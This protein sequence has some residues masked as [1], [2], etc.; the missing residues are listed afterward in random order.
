MN[1]SDELHYLIQEPGIVLLKLLNNHV[2]LVC[3]ESGQSYHPGCPHG[4]YFPGYCV[5]Q[6]GQPAVD[7]GLDPTVQQIREYHLNS[8]VVQVGSFAI[9]VD[10]L[11]GETGVPV[12]QP[13]PSLGAHSFQYSGLA[14]RGVR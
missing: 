10:N 11:G 4:F 14:D 1:L 3:M 9:V 8:C 7:E 13:A 2:R 12:C 6:G 5:V